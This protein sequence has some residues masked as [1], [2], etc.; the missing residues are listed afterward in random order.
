MHQ[1]R[2]NSAT[3]TT[4]AHPTAIPPDQREKRYTDV[5]SATLDATSKMKSNTLPPYKKEIDDIPMVNR[6]TNT[7][8][9]ARNRAETRTFIL[10]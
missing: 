9:L 7:D 2:I 6:T 8:K 4:R 5:N 3:E 1:V 10:Y